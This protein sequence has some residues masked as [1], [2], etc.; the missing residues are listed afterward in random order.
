MSCIFDFF[1]L[2][3]NVVAGMDQDVCEDGG[4]STSV[5]GSYT[6]SSCGTNTVAW[7]RNGGSGTGTI[8]FGSFDANTTTVTSTACGE[9]FLDY[10]VTTGGPA[11][12][13]TVS[14]TTVYF[15][16]LPGNVDAG[17]DQDVC[18]SS[19]VYSTTLSGSYDAV[20]CGT[21]TVAWTQISGVTASITGGTTLTP[22]ITAPSCGTYE[23][24]MD[25]TNGGLCTVSSTVTVDFYDLATNLNAGVDQEVC[26]D[27]GYNTSVTGSYTSSSCGTNTVAWSKNVSSTGTGTISFGTGTANTTTVS[28]TECGEYILD[29]T[30]TTGGPASCSTVSSTTI[31]FYDLPTNVDAGTD[32]DVCEVTG[33]FSTSLLGSYDV[34]SCDAG[35][36]PSSVEWTKVSGP[37]VV[38][39]SSSTTVA[40][41][42]AVDVCGDYVFAF[43]VT[44][45]PSCTV[46]NTVA[47]AFY[48]LPT[49]VGITADD[50]VCGLTTGLEGA[51]TTSCGMPD[52][53]WTQSA[54][55]G[56]STFSA[57]DSDMTD[58]TVT[59]CGDY[60]FEY[61]VSQISGCETVSSTTVT[62][63]DTPDPEIVGSDEVY[64]CSTVTYTV[65]DLATCNDPNDITYSWTV[66]GGLFNGT[67]TQTTGT[68]VSVT[69]DQ[70]TTSGGLALV[71]SVDPILSPAC[72]TTA[73]PLT[74]TKVEPTFE[75]QI[76]YW[77]EFETYM[78]TPFP[79]NIG[80]T[81][82]EDYFYVEFYD[83]SNT[84]RD[85]YTSQP[86]LMLG[87]SGQDSTL[88]S[89]YGFTIPTVADGCS[90][91]YYVKVWDGGLSYHPSP[92]SPNVAL[93]ASYTY[94]NWGGVNATDAYAIQLMA[95]GSDLNSSYPWVGLTT[96]SP[97]YG[98][99]SNNIA[100]VNTSG[101][102]I[103]ALDAL[104]VNYRAV[105]LLGTYPNSG[106]NMF[107]P[108]FAVAGRMVNT[109]PEITWSSYFDY[110]VTKNVVCD[111]IEFTHSGEDYFYF[112]DAVDHKY[113][114]TSLPWL[115][116]ANFMNIYYEAEGDINGS[117]VPTSGG[118]KSQ[119]AID[120]V[121]ENEVGT[122]VDQIITIPVSVDRD[123]ELNAI[124]LFMTFRNDLIEV[125]ETNY[126]KDYVNINNEEGML[127]IGW[128]NLDTR[129]VVAD[130]AIALIK[131]RV[132]AEIPAN[133]ELFA[134][135]A[136]T[137]LA[138]ATATPISDLTLKTIG[139][140][141]DKIHINVSE[142]VASNYPNPFDNTTTITYTLP[143]TGK[144]KVT[145]LNSM[146]SVIE[147][148]VEAVQ[149]AGVQSF[150]YN[151][152][153]NPG[154]YFYSITLQ[155]ETNTFS[156]V[157]RMIVVN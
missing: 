108:N 137:E 114:S 65:N 74:V 56:T 95:A 141:T 19:S 10:T 1:D 152:E 39:F 99:Y 35:P 20:T 6:A 15:Y 153:I 64:T 94:T 132:L 106:S 18:E 145:I 40:S 126:D 13:S 17:T 54:G 38:T 79:T 120:L 86:N 134:L 44:N 121:Y 23:F 81:Y 55:P 102:T 49:G 43:S 85:T 82:P 87:V 14:S 7:T 11:S 75:G 48:D 140:T 91:S 4:F 61:A 155:G 22:S 45:G 123:A 77:N 151:T 42:V 115:P 36:T 139:V 80:G 46:S 92:P 150:V 30:V 128:F 63:Y 8:T 52:V 73:T 72:E 93:G 122:K 119:S 37:G 96:D 103:T 67:V 98:F 90:G 47:V 69:W 142:L 133:T 3:T 110:C 21:T 130:E 117:Y 34:L 29:F 105:G 9:Y 136:N 101:T 24:Q 89:Y 57:S 59:E 109:L 146:G 100:D 129:D 70:Y 111:D 68:S 41:D 76:K 113:T 33:V 2:A 53:L 16:D 12:C 124:S 26:E 135:A 157:K 116:E 71:A 131:V 156:T 25:V 62:F 154:V 28:S 125:L 5:T 78:P 50:K 60:T 147:T 84:L 127:N 144:V 83:N 138:D 148:V 143:E 31:Y 58:V 104:I 51:F 88:M 149:E 112:D 118:F 32:E 97:T 27:G 107:S 66:T